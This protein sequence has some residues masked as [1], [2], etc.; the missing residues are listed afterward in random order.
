M[1]KLFKVLSL[2]SIVLFLSSCALPFQSSSYPAWSTKRVLESYTLVDGRVVDGWLGA[3]IG[4]KVSAKWYDYTVNKVEFLNEYEGYKVEDN[5]VTLVHASI[6]IKN[7]SDKEVYLFEDDFALVWDLEKE[8]RSYTTSIA[9]YTDTMLKEMALG[10]G[11]EKTIDTVYEIKKD[12][13]KPMA[14]YYYEQYNDGQKGNKYYVY[15]K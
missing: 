7:T 9:P 14:I 8:E 2:T 6:T 12:V 15:I 3:N 11:E 1:K 13:K 10:I 5:D 4:E